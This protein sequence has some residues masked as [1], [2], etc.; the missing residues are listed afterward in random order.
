MQAECEANNCKYETCH[1]LACEDGYQRCW[2][3]MLAEWE[4]TNT[5][6]ECLEKDR[7]IDWSATEKIECYVDVLL[8]SPTKEE[9]L[10]TCGTETCL[11]KYRE[12]HYKHCNTICPEVDFLSED[13]QMPH[14]RREGDQDV[15]NE[16]ENDVR[17]KHRS[18]DGVEG[19]R[20]TGHLD[21]DY[22]LT[23]CCTPCEE[24]PQPPCGPQGDYTGGWD[25]SSYMWLHYGQFG[26]FETGDIADFA[27][28]ICHSGEHS[29]SYG[30]N[31]C[32][33]L[34]CPDMPYPPPQVCPSSPLAP[35]CSGYPAAY[36]YTQHN[37]QCFD[38]EGNA[39]ACDADAKCGPL[40]TSEGMQYTTAHGVEEE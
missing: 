16:G 37:L 15:T 11:N 14:V 17:T 4:A 40:S 28:D 21:L 1:W 12:T 3:R 31:L 26:H 25:K 32:P 36:D 10:A 35:A 30:Y 39:K 7:K 34:N 5:A 23:P 27:A 20:C 6:K 13:G 24:R 33:C 19:G 18:S 22:Q 2:A 8:S 38:E 29:Y 9:L